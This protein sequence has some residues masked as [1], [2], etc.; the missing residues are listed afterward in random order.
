VNLEDYLAKLDPKTAA[1]VRT[2]QEVEIVRLPLASHGLT[3]ALEGGIAKGRITLVYGPQSSGKTLLAQQSISKW[4]KEGLVCCFVDVEGTWDKEWA[5]KLG[6]DND[7]L[8][9]IQAKSSARIEEEIA[10]HLHAGIDVIVVDSISNIMPATFIDGQELKG[11]EER[12]QIG[13]HA[14]AITALINGILYAN[15]DTAIFLISQATFD[16]S[17]MHPRLIPHGGKK[18]LFAAS[19]I[20]RLSSSN[21]EKEQ[22]KG[23]HWVG[24]HVFNA[25]IGR[26]VNALVEKN[27]LGKSHGTAKYNM[28]YAGKRVGIDYVAEVIEEASNFDVL[29]GKG[30]MSW[31]GQKWQGKANATAHFRE[32]PEDLEMLLQDLRKVKENVGTE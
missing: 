13:A 20:I 5:A 30:W 32:F 31:R 1:R 6:V 8:I 3:E 2:A 24:S 26:E 4:Q 25:P 17:G 9:L 12:K 28:Y 18:V 16:F 19:Q 27:K 10:P 11:Q 14:K 7:Q 21:T 22:I 23:E 29:E 15:E